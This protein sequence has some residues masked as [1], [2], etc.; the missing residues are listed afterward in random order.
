MLAD[1]AGPSLFFFFQWVWQRLPFLGWFACV[2]AFWL[3]KPPQVLIKLKVA[4]SL[5][6]EIGVHANLN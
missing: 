3:W 4:S 6:T 5:L 2:F 1:G